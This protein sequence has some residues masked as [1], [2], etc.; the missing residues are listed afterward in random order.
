MQFAQR[1][2]FRPAPAES[3]AHTRHLVAVTWIVIA[4]CIAAVA[5]DLA[6]CRMDASA[7]PQVSAPAPA[8]APALVTQPAESLYFPDQYRNQATEIEPL[9]PQF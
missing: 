6:G 8:V 3:S 1:D 9:P 7:A 4:A 5:I 2:A